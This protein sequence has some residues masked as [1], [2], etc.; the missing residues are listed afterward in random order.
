MQHRTTHIGARVLLIAGVLS[1]TVWVAMARGEEPGFTYAHGGGGHGSGVDLRIDSEAS[2][3]GAP[4]PAGTW[5]IKNLVPGVDKFFNFVDIKPG[6][7]GENTVSLHAKKDPLW[8]CVEFLNLDSQENGINEPESHEPVN[9]FADDM[10]FFA[11]R[12]DG[13]NIFEVGEQP[14]FGPASA[15]DALDNTVYPLFDYAHGPAI[16]KGATRYFGIY[17]CAGDLAVDVPTAT[18]TCDGEALGNEA[19]TDT[20]NVDV[21]LVAVSAKDEPKFKCGGIKLP[22]PGQYCK[23]GEVEVHNDNSA[24]VHNT[25]TSYSSTGGNS[26][27]GDPSTSSGQATV[28]TGSA[29]ATSSSINIINT[30]GHSQTGAANIFGDFFRRH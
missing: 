20:M 12:D 11:W 22:P 15:T 23:L 13:D 5:E 21:Q 4:W 18:I 25:T 19:Q 24:T 27:S 3:N 29:T 7:R 17:W 10:E 1:L 30:L 14:I 16:P 2:Y 9:N 6:D 8:V 28:T 26:S